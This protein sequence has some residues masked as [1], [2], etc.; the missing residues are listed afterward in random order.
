MRFHNLQVLRVVA[1]VGVVAFHLGHHAGEMLGAGGRLVEWLR[2]GPWAVFPVPL[3]FALSGFV[4][5]HALQASPRGRFLFGRVLRLY[6]GY[7]VA[8]GAVTLAMWFTVWPP[9]F[10]LYA[11]PE[12]IG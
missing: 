11:R 7:W 9:E 8:A 6:P 3:F 4:L 10:R 2:T 1:A 5:S 12:L